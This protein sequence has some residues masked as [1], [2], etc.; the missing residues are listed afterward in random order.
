MGFVILGR[1]AETET[2]A[3]GGRIHDIR[4][5]RRG[6]FTSDPISRVLRALPFRASRTGPIF[7]GPSLRPATVNY[8]GSLSPHVGTEGRGAV[9]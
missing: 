7:Q 1:I 3:V 8:P 5:L 4:R 2:I 9:V 6:D